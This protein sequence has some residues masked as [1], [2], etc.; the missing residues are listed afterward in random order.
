MALMFRVGVI[1]HNGYLPSADIGFHSSIIN[2]ILD[3]GKLPLRNPYHMGGEPLATPPGY[4]FFISFIVFFT[5]MPLLFAQLLIAVFFSSFAVFPTYLIS[6]KIWRSSSAGFLSAFF[7]TVS[8]LSLEMLGWGGYTNVISLTLILITF[9][10]F[11]KDAMSSDNF[12]LF[13]AA[14]L[15]GSLI[16]THLFSLFV[17]FPILILYISLLLL[18]KALKLEGTNSFQVIRFFSISVALGLLFVSPWLLRVS[19]FYFGMSSEGA[20]LG[21]LE[22]NR[23][24]ILLSRYVDIKIL[25]L[26]GAVLPT[27]FMFKSSR[28]R[29]VDSAS[30]LLI[31]WYIVPLI[32]TQAYIVGVFV[33]YSRFMYFADFPGILIL[34]GA[35]F[36]LFRYVLIAIKKYSLAKWNRIG[37]VA[38]KIALPAILLSVYLLSPSLITPMDASTKIDF[39]T[40]VKRPEVTA[41]GW[42]QKKTADSAVLVADHFYGW[43]LSGV[44]QRSTLSAAGLEFLLYSHEV[45]VAKSAQLL[46]DTDYYIDNGLIQVREDGPYIAR[47]NPIFSIET[48]KGYSHPLFHFDDN[49]TSIFFERKDARGTV[50][51]FDLKIVESPKISLS[52]DSVVLT[53]TRENDFLKVE[54]TLEVNRGVRFAELSYEIET[55]EAEVSIG[56]VSLILQKREGWLELNE[57]MMGL[58]DWYE[59]VCAQIIFKE[60][61]PE[62]RMDGAEF[63]Y[64]T[65]ENSFIRINFLVG[66]FDADGM[67][68]E[69]ILETYSEYLRNPQQIAEEEFQFSTWDYLETIKN[70]DV[71]FVVC[72][73]Q[74]I[75]PKFSN[76]PNFQVVYKSPKVAIFKVV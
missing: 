43:W 38:L 37:K 51:L 49:E 17:L 31:V 63:L 48:K 30:L 71:S 13:A 10:L 22:E 6:S 57:W 52:E 3:E 53:I 12:N 7:V 21:G 25:V 45:E 65:E 64:T 58:Y 67:K 24:L 2:L 70:Y 11:I 33:D 73:D 61:Y 55:L 69:K 35:T 19:G 39:Y 27:L 29:Y 76:D 56:W 4:H 9:Y 16:L 20:F 47:H 42:I 18:S 59:K 1:F 75:Y 46:L 28:G 54:K 44:A 72:R 36:Y 50:D 8:S 66:V 5:G 23:K 60:Q 62:V 74:G 41:M 14:L 26:I 15:F 34:S 40:F 68:Y 32:M